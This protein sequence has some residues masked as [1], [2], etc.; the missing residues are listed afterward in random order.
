MIFAV[1]LVLSPMASNPIEAAEKQ[2]EEL[3]YPKS[4]I[5]ISSG[6]HSSK[7]FRT[8]AHLRFHSISHPEYGEIFLEIDRPTPFHSWQLREFSMENQEGMPQLP[9][10]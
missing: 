10:D 3:G 1:L 4:D 9:P 7:L 2:A 5:Q 8:S 6:G